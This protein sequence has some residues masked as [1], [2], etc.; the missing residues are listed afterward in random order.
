MDKPSAK[1]EVI[2][3]II[4][5]EGN[6]QNIKELCAI[7]GVSRSGRSSALPYPPSEQRECNTIIKFYL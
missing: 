2:H 6:L 4:S 7:A 1:Y 3:E 5:M